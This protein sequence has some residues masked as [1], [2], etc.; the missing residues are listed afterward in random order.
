[1]EKIHENMHVFVV[2]CNES[3]KKWMF[4]CIFSI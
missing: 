4:P 3:T 1:M 2:S